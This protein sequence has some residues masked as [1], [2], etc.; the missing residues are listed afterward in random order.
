MS[1]KLYDHITS[2][3]YA[4][5]NTKI[6]KEQKKAATRKFSGEQNSVPTQRNS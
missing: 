3:N 6:Q 2:T 4:N 1:K 5:I